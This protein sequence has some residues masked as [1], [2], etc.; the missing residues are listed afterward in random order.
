MRELE[1][2][3]I[4]MIT[5]GNIFIVAAGPGFFQSIGE[6]IDNFIDNPFSSIGAILDDAVA[7]QSDQMVPEWLNGN[8]MAG[9]I[10]GP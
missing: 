6:N 2:Y 10:P 8:S 9:S 3:E 5:G 4:D 7:R 1:K